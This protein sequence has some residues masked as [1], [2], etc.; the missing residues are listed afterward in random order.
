M[1]NQNQNSNYD[2]LFK[3]SIIFGSIHLFSVFL[4]V[5]KLKFFTYYLDL[6]EFS[7]FSLF[8]SLVILLTAFTGFGLERSATREIATAY[9]NCNEIQISNIIKTAKRV[10]III[11]LLSIL[12]II[13]FSKYLS[14]LTFGNYKYSSSIIILSFSIFFTHI[15]SIQIAILKGLQ[16]FK[17]LAKSTFLGNFISVLSSIILIY[18]F[19]EKGIIPS[20]FIS[21]LSLLIVNYY[22]TYNLNLVIT[23]FD[24]K[25]FN[26]IFRK[27]FFFGSVLTISGTFTI[28]ESYIV[29]IY[30]REYGSF[31]HI[32]QYSAGFTIINSIS[33]L[34]FASFI[35]EYYPK[36]I[37]LSRNLKSLH[38]LVKEQSNLILILITPFLIF[39]IL[40][41]KFLLPFIFTQ[42][43]ISIANLIVW[44]LFGLF[45]K[46]IS[47]PIGLI[48][49]SKGDTKII[50]INELTNNFILLCLNIYFY[51]YF[52]LDGLGISYFISTII[53]F[54]TT[55][56]IAKYRY[57]FYL[58][59]SHFKITIIYFLILILSCI[60]YFFTSGFYF[61]FYSFS[62][63]LFI[64]FISIYYFNN[65]INIINLL[66][67]LK[68]KL[69]EKN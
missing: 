6:I 29:K 13:L 60:V 45:F 62:L 39:L 10:A 41:I 57:D 7:E 16:K 26:H 61:I 55:F 51:N 17:N 65:L 40:Y 59:L 22:Y 21:S 31:T 63:S 5:F 18:F 3:S 8:S 43:Y 58:P 49:I 1:F 48:F 20:F 12:L 33:T 64:F 38:T 37:L 35:T 52:G 36:L 19:R 25:S 9:Q 28:L 69:F 46:I 23:T 44:C 68:I 50:L 56:L 47:L 54:F 42:D 24:Y 32:G 11:G 53:N 66:K 34:I 27:I 30:I 4:F 67:S 15:N 2:K 14:F